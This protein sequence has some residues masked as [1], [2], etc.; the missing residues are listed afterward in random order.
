MMKRY[1]LLLFILCLPLLGHTQVQFKLKPDVP[2]TTTANQLAYPW[3]GG[4]NTPQFSSI[5][6][7]KDGQPDLFIFDRT[8]RKVYTWLAVQQNGTWKYS[9]APE[10]EV[11]FPEELNAWVLLRDYNCDGLADIFTST[12]LGIRVYKQETAPAGQLKFALAADFLSYKSSSGNNINMQLNSS[13]VPAITDMD[14][15]GDLDIVMAEFSD[16]YRLEHYR[17][18]QTEQNLGCGALTFIQQSNWWGGITE[19]EGC[20]NFRFGE[21]CRGTTPHSASIT[22]KAIA[23]PL[24]TG[25][26]GSSILLLDTDGDGDKDLVMGGLEC[27]NLVFMQNRGDKDNAKMTDFEAFFPNATKP[28]SF[29]VFPSAY[30]EDVTF[31]GIP[32]LL[33]APTSTHDLNNINFEQSVW[34][35]KN[36][37]TAD[38]PV[39]EFVQ[40]DFLQQL[41][42]DESEGAYPAFADLDGD[43]DLDM[44][45]GNNVSFRNGIY[46]SSVSHYE[47]T[48]TGT[49]PAFKLITKDYLNLSAKNWLNIRPAFADMNSDGAQDFVVTYFQK[50]GKSGSHYTSYYPNGAAKNAPVKYEPGYLKPTAITHP[51][52][53]GIAFFDAD[54]DGDLDYVLGRKAGSLQLY[55][56]TGNKVNPVY[57]LS[58]TDFGKLETTSAQSNRYPAITDLDGNERADLLIVDDTGQL[59]V[60]LNITTNLT[61]KF[62]AQN[63]LL[64][65]A[66]FDAPQATRF[67]KGLS[68]TAAELGGAGKLYLTI[69][70]INGGIYLLEQ[71]AGFNGSLGTEA[72][73]LQAFPNPLHTSKNQQLTV[74]A[75]EEVSINMYDVTGKKVYASPAISRTHRLPTPTGKGLYLIRG[76]TAADRQV[77]TKVLIY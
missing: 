9:Y 73:T 21:E 40:D 46:T 49:A 26:S 63:Q 67:G 43:G 29:P 44:L 66:L 13:D 72:L 17:N 60:Y 28:A 30:Y 18:M 11:F 14:G 16:G 19:C 4:L 76:T 5:D 65:N 10:Y 41:M 2:V 50:E 35:Y 33:V 15:D 31:D 34:L 45:V 37:G 61:G 42:L 52:A 69:G 3:S 12:A 51:D 75:S 8:A 62:T 47:N 59:Q 55:L 54:G 58:E 68:I 22:Q 24:H 74:Q 7:N 64:E 38:K 20:T 39:F 36:I 25:H 32:D 27:E 6:L 53:A 57:T 77:I 1:F 70:S 23:A 71:T 56:N 48:G